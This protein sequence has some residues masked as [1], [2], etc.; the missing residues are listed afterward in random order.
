MERAAIRSLGGATLGLW[1]AAA[2][3][4]ASGATYTYHSSPT[5][6]LTG[7]PGPGL[8]DSLTLSFDAPFTLAPDSVYNISMIAGPIAISSWS[9]S[10]T[11]YGISLS[12]SGS[13]IFLVPYPGLIEGGA[14]GACTDPS[15]G[16]FGGGIQ[17]D[18]HGQIIQWN[19]VADAAPSDGFLTFITFN[20]PG[21]GSLDGLVSLEISE[22]SVLNKQAGSW[23]GPVPE[24]ATWGLM[25]LGFLSVGAAR[26]RARN[27][28]LAM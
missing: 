4:S 24:P 3:V 5:N 23:S 14:L 27:R 9:A 28:T 26:R 20:T 21:L 10:D 18:G 25:I 7:S 15:I 6:P 19:L 22:A 13:P 12:G 1:V 8:T 2:S 16:C 17:T 11:F